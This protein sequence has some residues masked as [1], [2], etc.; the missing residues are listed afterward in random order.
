[1][2]P[3][4]LFSDTGMNFSDSSHGYYRSTD[5]SRGRE[6]ALASHANAHLQLAPV[7]DDLAHFDVVVRAERLCQIGVLCQNPLRQTCFQG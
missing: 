3:C 7:E 2:K 5:M 4:I 6:G 1:M